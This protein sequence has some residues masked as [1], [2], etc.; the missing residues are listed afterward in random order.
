MCVWESMMG[1]ADLLGSLFFPHHMLRR[2][3]PRPRKR[4]RRPL[5]TMRLARWC[6]SP[7]ARIRCA[8]QR[9]LRSIGRDIISVREW[10]SASCMWPGIVCVCGDK[11]QAKKFKVSPDAYAQMAIQLAYYRCA[12][13]RV[14]RVGTCFAFFSART[15]LAQ[16]SM[17]FVF[18]PRRALSWQHVWRSEGDV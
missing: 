4:M 1:H 7:T 3:L 18:T 16:H 6:T 13:T 9:V 12:C 2:R 17:C 8:L 14:A 15:L 10:T 5:P 11:T